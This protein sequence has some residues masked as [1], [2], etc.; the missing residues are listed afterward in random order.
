MEN[1]WLRDR[2]HYERMQDSLY[3]QI[4]QSEQPIPGEP[5]SIRTV[6]EPHVSY[7]DYTRN[8]PDPPEQPERP[9]AFSK[10]WLASVAG[11]NERVFMGET[12]LVRRL[13]PT[14]DDC[15]RWLELVCETNGF[16]NLCRLHE[17]DLSDEDPELFD[18]VGIE[19]SGPEELLALLK[20]LDP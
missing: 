3:D 17:V 7:A 6:K 14:F 15:D 1:L 10:E 8:R 12:E 5:L 20:I 18:M 16:F 19:L 11:F 2:E 4:E 13:P 9:D